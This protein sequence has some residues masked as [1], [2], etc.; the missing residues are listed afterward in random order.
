MLCKLLYQWTS[1]NFNQVRTRYPYAVSCKRSDSVMSRSAEKVKDL[2]PWSVT[3][4]DWDSPAFPATTSTVGAFPLWPATTMAYQE[5]PWRLFLFLVGL[6][7]EP[8]C[9]CFWL[10]P[11]VSAFVLLVE[12][13][14]FCFWLVCWLVGWWV[15]CCWS[16]AFVFLF[17]FLVGF[18]VCL[19]F[20]CFFLVGFGGG[21]GLSI[22]YTE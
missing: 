16:F 19:F 9:F 8:S 5:S 17:L 7:V 18:F 22:P 2:G 10:S 1:V 6:L 20:C 15:C 4:N 3:D 11:A 13:G 21:G 14:C 12:P